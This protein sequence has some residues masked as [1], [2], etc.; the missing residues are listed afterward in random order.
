M[1]SGEGRREAPKVETRLPEL[2][3][4]YQGGDGSA[5][6][7]LYR[8]VA[9]GM[10]NYLFGFT[11]SAAR[12]EDLLQ[13]VFLRVHRVRHT[14]LPGRPVK[15]WLYAIARHA[16]I[17][18]Q[19][20]RARERARAVRDGAPETAPPPA[21][22]RGD[23]LAALEAVPP[24][25]RE[26]LLLTKLAGFSTREAAAALGTSEGAIKVK[27]F[28]ALRSLRRIFTETPRGEAQSGEGRSG[29][30]MGAEGT[31]ADA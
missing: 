11:G 27:V 17:D 5:L 24:T 25:Q 4:R 30:T 16:A 6:A 8:E 28:R 19:R 13:E 3:L 9:P 12:S 7:E 20:R 23:L 15:P 14:Y 18:A 26:A 31:E 1:Q 10:I 29:A 2:M 22:E 21:G